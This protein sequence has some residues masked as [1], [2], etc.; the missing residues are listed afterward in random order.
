ME[1]I[2]HL[3]PIQVQGALWSWG[4]DGGAMETENWGPLPLLALPLLPP[5]SEDRFLIF[6]FCENESND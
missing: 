2:I 4:G 1:T 5:A 6:L 3:S